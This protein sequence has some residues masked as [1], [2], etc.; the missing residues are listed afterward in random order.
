MPAWLQSAL[1]L[2]ALPE[3]GLA[4]LFL[5]SLLSATLLP[6]GSL[7]ALFG[8]LKLNPD[9]FWPAMIVATAGN[10]AGGVVNWW[11]GRGARALADR[12][13][14]SRWHE[15]A[16]SLLTR[17]GPRACL[18]AWTP[19]FGDPLCAVAGWL[20]LP[21]VPC[22]AYMAIGMFVRYVA[23]SAGLLHLFPGRIDF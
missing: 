7:P 20:R 3:F 12:Y 15:R 14:R 17:L 6:L 2:L 16:L 23:V 4:G 10:V 21:L 19:V 9:L 1:A 8:L 13:S 18:L 5:V 22:A 11:I